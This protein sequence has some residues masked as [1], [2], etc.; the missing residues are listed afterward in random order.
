MRKTLRWVIL[1]PVGIVLLLLGLANREPVLLSF[2]PFGGAPG[3]G[4]SVPLFIVIIVSIMVGVL[5]GG[6]ALWINQGRHR[7]S[8][9]SLR[10]EAER[11]RREADTLKANAS[12]R[13]GVPMPL[14]SRR[15]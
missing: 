8:A 6:I 13:T 3:L 14:L 11:L 10:R 2:D 1:V 12:E 7:R 5:I 4:V 9:R 15:G